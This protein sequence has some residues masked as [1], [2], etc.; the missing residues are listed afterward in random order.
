MR[1]SEAMTPRLNDL[2]QYVVEEFVEHYR[3]GTL[4]RRD[5]IRRVLPVAGGVAA[6]ATVLLALGCAP[7]PAAAPT[8]APAPTQPATPTAPVATS[9]VP[10]ATTVPTNAPATAT[11]VAAT[12]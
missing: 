9:T 8:S 12:T 11:S 1:S 4:S 7:G 6:T 2:Q 3:E 10:A 5:L